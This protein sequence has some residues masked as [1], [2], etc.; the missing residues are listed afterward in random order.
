MSPWVPAD[1]GYSDE[2]KAIN[3]LGEWSNPQGTKEGKIQLI[4]ENT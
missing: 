3:E 2:K 1:V 4:Y